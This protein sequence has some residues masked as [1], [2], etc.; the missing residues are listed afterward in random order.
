M[1]VVSI[2][3][4]FVALYLMHNCNVMNY[5]DGIQFRFYIRMRE[6]KM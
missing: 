2:V 4:V 5:C 1:D 6:M 3:D